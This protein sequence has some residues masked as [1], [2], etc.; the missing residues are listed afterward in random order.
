MS[1]F[2]TDNGF[3][4]PVENRVGNTCRKK[5]KEKNP[6][7]LTRQSLGSVARPRSVVQRGNL[8]GRVQLV[9]LNLAVLLSSLYD[10]PTQSLFLNYGIFYYSDPCT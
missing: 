7:L 3:G 1:D 4:I 2:K 5:K 10:I 9:K 6:F 8:Y